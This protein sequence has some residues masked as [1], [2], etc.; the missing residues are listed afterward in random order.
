MQSALVLLLCWHVGGNVHRFWDTEDITEFEIKFYCVLGN[1]QVMHLE[2]CIF[3]WVSWPQHSGNT[4]AI[5]VSLAPSCICW[6]S[7]KS[8]WDIIN[9]KCISNI[10]DLM[11][12]DTSKWSHCYSVLCSQM[13]MVIIP[14]LQILNAC[15]DA[16]CWSR[17]VTLM[18]AMMLRIHHSLCSFTLLRTLTWAGD[19]A[20]WFSPVLIST[21]TMKGE[22]SPF[23]LCR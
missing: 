7:N 13:L 2:F 3:P 12:Q 23:Q 19:G 10:R 16:C 18:W 11:S 1:L 14:S 20:W 21:R 4:T 9:S 5:F 8:D 22:K 6:A 15:C 17:N